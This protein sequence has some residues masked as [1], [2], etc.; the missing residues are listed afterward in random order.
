VC[1]AVMNVMRGATAV[2]LIALVAFVEINPSTAQSVPQS[3]RLEY[4]G[5]VQAVVQALPEPFRKDVKLSAVITAMANGYPTEFQ[6]VEIDADQR[7]MLCLAGGKFVYDDGLTK[8]FEERL[9]NPDIK[10]MF[11]QTY[12]LTNPTDRLPEDFDPGRYR[13]EP[14]FRALYGESKAAVEKNCVTVEFCGHAVKFNA[15][16]GAA[17][18]LRRVST[19]LEVVLARQPEL[20]SYVESLGGTLNWRKVAGTER[21]SDHAFGTA[22][23]LNPGKS[24]YWRWQPPAR[25]ATFSRKNWPTE[26]IETFE[27]HGFI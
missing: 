10:D 9:A 17:D 13:V 5:D 27:R 14:L 7:L 18:A 8:T 15:R 20:R 25:M 12:P 11:W 1:A 22:I 24:A 6:A 19:D 3:R 23:D 2:F 26:I 21:L 16:C 4:K